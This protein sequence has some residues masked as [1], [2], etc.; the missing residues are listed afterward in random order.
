MKRY[1]FDKTIYLVLVNLLSFL[2]W[3]LHLEYI[4]LPLFLLGM[5]I[6]LLFQ[7]ETMYTIPILFASLF[8]ISQTEWNFSLIPFYLYLVPVLLFLGFII[9]IVRYKVKLFS[10]ELLLPVLML[11]MSML[12]STTNAVDVNIYY[13]FYMLVALIYLFIYLFYRSTISGN[14]IHY[15]LKIMVFVGVLIAFQVLAFYIKVDDIIIAIQTKELDLGWGLSNF[16]ATYLIM[17]IPATFY[18][19]KISKHNLFYIVLGVFQ[20][21]MLLLTLSRGGILTFTVIFPFLL[22]Y[23]FHTGEWKKTAINLLV[24]L[25]IVIIVIYSNFALFEAIYLRFKELLFDDSG[26]FE[27]YELAIEKFLSHPLFGVGVFSRI[28]ALGDFRMYHNTFLHTL[29]SFGLVGIVALIW[30][31]A[32]VYKIVIHQ[33][34]TKTMILGISLLGANIHGLIDNVYYMPQFMILFFVII[35]VIEV[36]NRHYDYFVDELI[37]TNGLL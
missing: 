29:A 14:F 21:L 31:F 24:S 37:Q 1:F 5:V 6:L 4:G 15:L 8:M 3:V 22:F 35:A 10:G 2:F 36:S 11:F 16:V 17:F 23:L 30:Q 26:R 33:I 28:D 19:I 12:L 13:L 34:K 20:I 27:I 18:Y 7:K 9:H 25:G 32:R